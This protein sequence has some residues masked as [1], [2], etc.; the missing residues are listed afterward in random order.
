MFR[1][2][3]VAASLAAFATPVA[4]GEFMPVSM[5]AYQTAAAAGR[6]IVFHVRAPWCPVSAAQDK[7][8]DA[9]MQTEAYNDYLVLNVDFDTDKR[10]LAML[11]VEKQGTIIVNRGQ[12]ELARATGTIEPA[13]I[14]ALVAQAQAA[15]KP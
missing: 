11:R 9:L 7:V 4:A 2:L 1:I 8:L 10:A 6:P 15:P 14:A 5:A 12:V 13:A 3:L